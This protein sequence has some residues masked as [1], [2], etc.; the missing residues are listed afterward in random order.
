MSDFSFHL[1]IN[2][3]CF[4]YTSHSRILI[5]ELHASFVT[6]FLNLIEGFDLNFKGRFSCFLISFSA[7]I[8]A[9]FS[10]FAHFWCWVV[11]Y[12]NLS[13]SVFHDL[14]WVLF[15][16]FSKRVDW[17]LVDFHATTK[18]FSAEGQNQLWSGQLYV[19]RLN[20]VMGPMPIKC[21]GRGLYTIFSTLRSM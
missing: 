1:N 8:F 7:A 14:S 16:C 18:L 17:V 15:A 10:F 19:P 6:N 2:L 4:L 5:L 11:N 20:F 12:L 3:Y 9:L 21:S 13:C